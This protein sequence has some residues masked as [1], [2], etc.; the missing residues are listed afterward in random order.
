[1]MSIDAVL[2]ASGGI[3]I[4]V[5]GTVV[6]SAATGA[7]SVGC[8]VGVG[9]PDAPAPAA[10]VGATVAVG[11]GVGVGAAVVAAASGDGDADGLTPE[12][13]HAVGRMIRSP[14]IASRRSAVRWIMVR[15]PLDVW[16]ENTPGA[17]RA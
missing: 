8:G 16:R 14:A 4:L 2:P 7:R 15:L 6:V 10:V 5:S 12:P 9:A 11:V 3:G 17:R 13:P 1:M